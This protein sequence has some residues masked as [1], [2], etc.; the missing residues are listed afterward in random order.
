MNKKPIPLT[1]AT[2]RIQFIGI[3]QRGERLYN[4]NY[5]TLLQEIKHK[6][7]WKHIPYL[8]TVCTMCC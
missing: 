6:Y 3:N 1:I 2:K 5:K 7:K 8:W 4:G